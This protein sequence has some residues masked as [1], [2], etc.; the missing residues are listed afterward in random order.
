M[1]SIPTRLIRAFGF[2]LIR[3]NG[4][5][6]M[7]ILRYTLILTLWVAATMTAA[8]QTS[9]TRKPLAPITVCE[10]LSNR[11]F[12]NGKFVIVIGRWSPTD[13]GFWLVDNCEKQIKTDEYVWSNM[14]S[15][16]YDPSSP[17]AFPNGMK[18]DDA[19][20]NQKIVELKRRMKPS[21]EKVEWAVVYGRVE[22]QEEL[23][24]A[25]AGDGKSVFPAG[26]GH[27]NAAPAQVVYKDKDLVIMTGK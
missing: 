26:Y 12:Y 4:I 18:I 8:A 14:V 6:E 7:V 3:N 11:E 9:K 16:E 17:T 10:I 23:Q 27:L 5:H 21:K 22:T 1:Q 15:L 24:T 2:F 25:I 20:V 19:A 13:E